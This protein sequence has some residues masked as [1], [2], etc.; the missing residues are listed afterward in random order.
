MG[1]RFTHDSIPPFRAREIKT[2]RGA[3][4]LEVSPFPR[5]RNETRFRRRFEIRC[6]HVDF[7]GGQVAPSLIGGPLPSPIEQ[8]APS[9]M[10]KTEPSPTGRIAISP[11]G[12]LDRPRG[13]PEPYTDTET[14]KDADAS[15][16]PWS[17]VEGQVGRGN[18]P[19]TINV[20]VGV[21]PGE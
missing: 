13:M 4:S 17:E 14:D 8:T 5:V 12:R 16:S 11:V 15:S 20:E 10:G 9:P 1:T 6:S 21:R 2:S 7:H 18:A 19:T 3:L